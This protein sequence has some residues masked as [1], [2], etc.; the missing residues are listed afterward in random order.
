[1]LFDRTRIL[2]CYTDPVGWKDA[3][4]Q[5]GKNSLIT[6]VKNVKDVDKLLRSIV[7][8]AKGILLRDNICSSY[9]IL[10]FLFN[11]N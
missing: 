11:S 1:M 5:S 6:L 2:D 4:H 8:L 10:Y 9:E 3:V 7:D